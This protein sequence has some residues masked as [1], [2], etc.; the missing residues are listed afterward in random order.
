VVDDVLSGDSRSYFNPL[1]RGFE[2]VLDTSAFATCNA[3]PSARSDRTDAGGSGA[4]TFAEI[5]AAEARGLVAL[6]GH[7]PESD[8]LDGSA[9]VPGERSLC[10]G[11]RF[12]VRASW[13]DSAGNAAEA[14]AVPL[15]SDTGTFWF[16]DDANV[17]LVV[18]VLQACVLNDRFWV[19]AGGLTDVEVLLTLTD[20]TTGA[21]REYRNTL[22][23][24]YETVRDTSAFACP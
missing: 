11:G 17:E 10:L 23:Q 21:V 16:F 15:T 18:K 24:P 1:G 14:T 4:P 3:A 9:C 13:R 12:E 7:F 20:T 6:A 5:A 22:G 2:P 19:F 8:A